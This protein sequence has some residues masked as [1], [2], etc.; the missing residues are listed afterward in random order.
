MKLLFDQDFE[1]HSDECSPLG[2]RSTR[3]LNHAGARSAEGDSE[4][5]D[6]KRNSVGIKDDGL[7]N[8]NISYQAH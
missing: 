6:D 1:Y 2:P 5:L 7:N 4:W 8:G 3:S